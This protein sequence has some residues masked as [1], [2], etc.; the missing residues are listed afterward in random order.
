MKFYY[1]YVL[2]SLKDQKLYVGFT[3]DLR[4]RLRE[5]NQGEVLSTKVRRPLELMYF[6]GCPSSEKALKREKYFK[7]GYGRAFLKER[8]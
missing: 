8:I 7:S 5:H 6:E 2:R 1:T 3:G 4:N